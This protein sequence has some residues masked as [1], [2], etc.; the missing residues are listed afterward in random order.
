[1]TTLTVSPGL[2][3]TRSRS[4]SGRGHCGSGFDRETHVSELIDAAKA[5]DAAR[6]REILQASPSSA[7]VPTPAGESAL[8]AALYN[9]HRDLANE[10]ADA[11][12]AAG[13]PP[14]RFGGGGR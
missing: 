12:V 3:T 7:G 2:P 13:A 10:I 4:G 9:G 6:V 5:G 8:M 1:S 11:R 14:G